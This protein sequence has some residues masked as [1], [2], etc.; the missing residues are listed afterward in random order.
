MTISPVRGRPQASSRETLQEAAFELFLE[1]GYEA[2]TIG[3]IAQRAGVSRNTFFNYF[4]SKGDVFWVDLDDALKVVTTRLVE[5]PAGRSAL[6]AVRDALVVGGREMGS[7]QV[8][9]A[10]TQYALVG[11]AGDLISS[12]L[13]RLHEHFTAIELFLLTRTPIT[14]V[15]AK[16]AAY[17]VLGAAVAAVQIWAAAGISR[18]Q[19]EPYLL[20]ALDPVCAAF[21]TADESSS[22]RR[23]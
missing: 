1:K 18:G 21:A 6:Y 23:P 8:P 11:G 19:L 16:T 3:Q 14:A 22:G 10:L 4:S 13:T 9:W 7:L 5:T 17:A 2:T 12:A 20:E 15:R